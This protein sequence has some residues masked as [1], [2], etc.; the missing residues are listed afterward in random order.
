MR[1]IAKLIA[2]G[3]VVG[4]AAGRV[5]H[6]ELFTKSYA[7]K[8]NVALKAE[9]PLAEG[10]RLDTVEFVVPAEG[11][12]STFGGPKVKVTISN[13]GKKS[14]TVAIAIAVM[15]AEGHLVGVASG[16]TKLFP[17]RAERQITYTLDFGGVN[18][19]LG[20]GTVF[21]LSIEP[22]SGGS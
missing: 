2:V 18:A 14:V 8:P 13:L 5:V 1:P 15:N 4:M 12:T 9:T 6:A 3:L 11:Q 7:F 22:K 17:L 10:L 19:A 16:G 20:T 21:H